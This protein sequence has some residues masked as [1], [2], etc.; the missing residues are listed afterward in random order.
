MSVPENTNKQSQNNTALESKND[1]EDP[2]NYYDVI[3]D[4]D[5]FRH[6]LKEEGNND[7]GWNVQINKNFNY[8]EKVKEEY[9][10]IGVVGNGNRGKSFLLS[11]ISNFSFPIGYSVKTKG[12]SVKYPLEKMEGKNIVILD[13]AGFETPVLETSD[14]KLG[15]TTDSKKAIKTMNEIARDR[16]IV[17]YFT[18]NFILTYSNV[19]IAVV[20]QLTFSEQQLLVKIKEDNKKKKIFVVHNLF[21]FETIKQVDDYIENTLLKS[22]TFKLEPTTYVNFKN[23]SEEELKKENQI[24]YHEEVGDKSIEHLILSRE[25]TEAGNYY[26]NSTLLYLQNNITSETK[27]K[28]RPIIENVKKNLAMTSVFALEYPIK[29]ENIKYENSKIFVENAE[30]PIILKQIS[31]DSIGT[32]SFYGQAF[33]PSFNFFIVDNYKEVPELEKLTFNVDEDCEVK[34][35]K[36]LEGMKIYIIQIELPG[37][38]NSISHPSFVLSGDGKMQMTFSGVRLINNEEISEDEKKKDTYNNTIKS[39]NFS[40]F[41]ELANGLWTIGQIYLC[42]THIDGIITFYY[43]ASGQEEETE[44]LEF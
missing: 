2:I 26:N 23:K 11:K 19:I 31:T 32:S 5:S 35:Y 24:Y 13:S 8:E 16:Q 29:K 3:I 27:I 21:N 22:L 33:L 10:S 39:G 15:T 36:D 42:H 18:Q 34:E 7:W 4:I 17:E 14:F 28:K 43:C 1:K 9:V 41:F 6:L 20:G 40:L 37:I 30:K 38:I 25:E 44:E 12:I